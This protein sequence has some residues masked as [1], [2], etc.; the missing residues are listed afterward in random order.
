MSIFLEI[1]L[2]ELKKKIKHINFIRDAVKKI[3]SFIYVRLVTPINKFENIYSLVLAGLLILIINLVFFLYV[4]LKRDLI[5]DVQYMSLLHSIN[6][7]VTDGTTR[8]FETLA[9]DD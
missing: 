3:F 2:K 6:S 4:D 1:K 8:A 7:A 9:N 5:H